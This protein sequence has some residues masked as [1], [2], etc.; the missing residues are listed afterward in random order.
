METLVEIQ[1]KYKFHTDKNSRHTYLK[2]YDELFYPF[3]NKEIKLLEIGVLQGGSLMLWN[4][5]FSKCT[6]FGIDIDITSINHNEL[7]NYNNIFIIPKNFIILL[8]FQNTNIY[9]TLRKSYT[10]IGCQDDA[11]I[12]THNYFYMDELENILGHSPHMYTLYRHA[13]SDYLFRFCRNT[14]YNALLYV[15]WSFRIFYI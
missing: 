2:H 9:L 8:Y 7:W 12:H 5:Y 11:L 4:K 15:L 14:Y 13:I 1:N 6:L 3:Q 10:H